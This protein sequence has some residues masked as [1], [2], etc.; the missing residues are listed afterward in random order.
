MK[1]RLFLSISALC[2]AGLAQAAPDLSASDV[3][4]EALR[5]VA[6]ERQKASIDEYH[7]ARKRA[8][9]RRDD[10]AKEVREITRRNDEGL[11]D[12]ILKDHLN[13]MLPP[14]ERERR[15]PREPGNYRVYE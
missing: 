3:S 1:K 6:T 8:E 9:K 12:T 2:V 13:S 11:K 7:K 15:A 10:E 4:E 14:C 5:K